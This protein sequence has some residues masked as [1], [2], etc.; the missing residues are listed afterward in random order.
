MLNAKYHKRAQESTT[1]WEQEVAT[2][3]WLAFRLKGGC[4]T[5]Q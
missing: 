4:P 5:P 2:Q 1:F 3:V